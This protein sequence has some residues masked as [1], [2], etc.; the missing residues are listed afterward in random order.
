LDRII[1]L[2]IAEDKAVEPYE[3]LL[4]AANSAHAYAKIKEIFKEANDR[5]NSELFKPSKTI[6]GLV[7]DDKTLKDILSSLYYPECPYEFS[8]LPVSILGN[9]Y[10]Q[11]LGATIRLTDSGLVK[12]EEKPEVRKAG[13][14]Y[15]TPQYIVDYIVKNTVGEKI[16][17][18]SPQEIENIK[19]LDPACGS[20]SFLIGAYQ[21]LL[22]YHL[23]YYTD[24][25]NIKKAL[26]E[27]RVA[28]NPKGGYRLTIPE[29]QNILKNNIFGVDIDAQA[30]EVSKFSLLIKLMESETEQ[31]AAELFTLS[32]VEGRR[33]AKIL[34]SL[35]ANIK[36]GN[37]LIGKDFLKDNLFIDNEELQAINPFDWSAE[38]G[39]PEIMKRGGFDC[40]IGN[41]P[42]RR[43][44]DY[45][46]LMENIRKSSFGQK[47]YEGKMDFWYL[48]LHKAI[49]VGNANSKCSFIVNSYWMS[50]E[51]ASLLISR[52]RAKKAIEEIFYLDS[53]KVF[54]NVSG[55][56]MVFL[57]SSGN[58]KVT[59]K[60]LDETGIRNP[61]ASFTQNINIITYEKTSDALYS[62]GKINI[63]QES[64]ILH[65]INKF[66]PLAEVCSE[67]KQG[68]AENPHSINNKT[69]K[70][71]KNFVAGE[72]VFVLTQKEIDNLNLNKEEKGCLRKYFE[73]SDIGRYFF[74]ADT[75]EKILYLTKNNT[76]NIDQ[77]PHIKNHLYKFK[78]IMDGRRENKSGSLQYFHLHWPREESI[79]KGEKIVSLQMG[80]R[81]AFAYSSGDSFLGFD[82]NIIKCDK[83]NIK[84]L[85]AVLN[86]K[87]AFYWFKNYAKRRGVGLEISQG[88]LK[89][90]PI[91]TDF[92]NTEQNKVYKIVSLVDSMLTIQKQLHEAKSETDKKLY[93]QKAD[94]LDEQIDALVYELY[95][96]TSEEIQ[97][98]ENNK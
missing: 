9:I 50:G 82:T 62:L 90:L 58:K 54:E 66:T 78:K 61:E 74:P 87:L 65:K 67:I 18:L 41:P 13:G 12:I 39:F 72:G 88:T 51:G 22:D 4:K 15:Y 64:T 98:I 80:K 86:S 92:T 95:G 3:T 79:F 60:K 94:I 49:D 84:Y 43:E 73:T 85:L 71:D 47:Y 55:R 8:V 25:E 14:V 24:G 93:Q 45:E 36:R 30:V 27:E 6:D 28:A 77:Y 17:G 76:T 31:S 5:Y 35:E 46:D 21:Y 96:L 59:I 29:K 44:R 7:I 83:I 69:A 40:I 32:K 81:P 38:G 10:E 23:A 34:P 57:I 75:D 53:A 42:Y 11:F 16:K 37:S 1:F 48:F 52:L 70:L 33:D 2:R 20:G 26:K 91:K 89:L 56:H 97:I 63:E 68:I 19:V